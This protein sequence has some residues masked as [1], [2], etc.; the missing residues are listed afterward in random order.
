MKNGRNVAHVYTP[1]VHVPR[2]CVHCKERLCEYMD[3]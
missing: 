1:I 3:I 2:E